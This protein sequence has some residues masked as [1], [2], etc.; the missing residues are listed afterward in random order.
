MGLAHQQLGEQ[1]GKNRRTR[2]RRY[3]ALAAE[4]QLLFSVL[5][6]AS[7]AENDDCPLYPSDAADEKRGLNYRC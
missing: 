5:T 7:G 4:L 6:W 1:S 3:G 2:F